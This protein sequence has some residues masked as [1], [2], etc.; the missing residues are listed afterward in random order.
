MSYSVKI[1]EKYL[2]FKKSQPKKIPRFVYFYG[3]PQIFNYEEYSMKYEHIATWLKKY[4]HAK[5]HMYFERTIVH[6]ILLADKI[7][8]KWQ[9]AFQQSFEKYCYRGPAHICKNV[10]A[11]ECHNCMIY[12]SPQQLT[13][14]MYE[15]EMAS[16]NLCITPPQLE[17]VTCV[18][19]TQICTVINWDNSDISRCDETQL[20][21]FYETGWI[22]VVVK[23]QIHAY[24]KF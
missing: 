23:N 6:G 7:K 4:I 11:I 15:F 22:T 3:K 12:I 9:Y 18:H 5:D 13:E 17:T 8:I 1:Y 10:V 14:F 20:E 21:M 2:K 19:E 16:I 24:I